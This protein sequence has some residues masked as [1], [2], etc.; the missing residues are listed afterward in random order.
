[1]LR[2]AKAAQLTVKYGESAIR[3]RHERKE[4]EGDK[5]RNAKVRRAPS[6]RAQK[7]AWCLPLD[8]EAVEHPSAG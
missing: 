1:M 5:D 2:I 6:I 3:Q 7:H 8:G 4:G